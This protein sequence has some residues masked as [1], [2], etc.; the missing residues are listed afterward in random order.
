MLITKLVVEEAQKMSK[1]IY[2]ETLD[3]LAEN[4]HLVQAVAE[5]LIEKET[6]DEERTRP[7]FTTMQNSKKVL[8]KFLSK[9]FILSL[10]N[11]S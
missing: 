4:K 9:T 10:I 11:Q 8:L 5:A 2:Q 3:L 1:T 7:N 6:I